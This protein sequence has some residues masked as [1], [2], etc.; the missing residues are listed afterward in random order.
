MVQSY[1]PTAAKWGID[2]L[3]AHTQALRAHPGASPTDPGYAGGLK[4]DG[5]MRRS[6]PPGA[7]AGSRYRGDSISRATLIKIAAD[8]LSS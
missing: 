2:Q 8:G 5:C 1:L 3:Y 4:A 6:L 7:E